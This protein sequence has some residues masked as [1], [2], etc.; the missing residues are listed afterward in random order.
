MIRNIAL[1]RDGYQC[2]ICTAKATSVHHISY[3]VDVMYGSNLSP[4]VS[5][6]DPCHEKIEF[7]ED[8]NKVSDL[9]IKRA[10]YEA[11]LREGKGQ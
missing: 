5:L 8:G 2:R 6:C 3:D 4:L 7:D 11:L 9:D 1:Y 10:Q